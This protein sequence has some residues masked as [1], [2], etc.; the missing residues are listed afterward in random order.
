MAVAQP[1]TGGHRDAATSAK[2]F[3]EQLPL[4][5][6]HIP[7]QTLDGP[8]IVSRVVIGHTQDVMRPG[9]QADMPERYG[10]SQGRW[11]EAMARS[12]SPA[13]QKVE[14]MEV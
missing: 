1:G 10:H 13:T 3:I 12:T 14:P 8:W 7:S 2:A 11:Q 9:L 5:E 6:R 4:E